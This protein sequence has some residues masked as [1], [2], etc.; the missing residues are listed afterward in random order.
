MDIPLPLYYRIQQK[1]I[2]KIEN[3]ELRPNEKISSLLQKEKGIL[4]H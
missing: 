3:G 2:E 4:L 1:L